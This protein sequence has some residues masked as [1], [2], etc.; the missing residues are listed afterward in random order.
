MLQGSDQKAAVNS[1]E[2]KVQ[3]TYLIIFF[4]LYA[5]E[6][7]LR[8][9]WVLQK[10]QIRKFNNMNGYVQNVFPKDQPLVYV[11]NPNISDPVV[12][13]TYLNGFSCV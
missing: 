9:L 6:K 12:T 1:P 7:A 11:S 13:I 2:Q 8:F 10:P 3:E 5:I 4:P